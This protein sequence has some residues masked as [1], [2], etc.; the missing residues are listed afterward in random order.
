MRAVDG[1]NLELR[2]GETLAL[3]GESGCG[4]STLARLLCSL[5]EPTAG[6]VRF[7]DRDLASLRRR[8]L[9][10]L[11]QD[12][13]IV[14]QDPF[15]SLDPRMSVAGIVGEPLANFG[16]RPAVRESRV[17]ELLQLVG[18]GPDV[19][20]RR[21][22]E[23]SGG[24]RQRVGIA[25]ALALE[26]SVVI[27]DEPVSALDVSIQAQIINLLAQLKHSLGLTY[28]FISHDLGVVRH[29]ADRVAVMYLGAIVEVAD[30]DDLFARPAHPYTR[31]LL[32]AVPLPDPRVEQRRRRPALSGEPPSS[33]E[34]A[35]GCRFRTRCPIAQ[36]PGRCQDEEPLLGSTGVGASSCAC[37]FH[38]TPSDVTDQTEEA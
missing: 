12:L 15:A 18:L 29:L 19:A 5:L 31:A 16:A 36:V 9:R 32:D 22:H 2:R 6:H 25:R 23:L 3:I 24:Q 26:P 34:L 7:N 17:R 1:V 14:F 4:K 10:Q 8:E 28:L 11:R 30:A 38:G 21:P 35:S 33:T 13:Q 27:C 20:R 37:H